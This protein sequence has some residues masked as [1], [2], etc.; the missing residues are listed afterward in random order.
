MPRDDRVA[1]C[2]HLQDSFGTDPTV[3]DAMQLT[4]LEHQQPNDVVGKEVHQQF[5]LQHGRALRAQQFH[6]HGGLDVPKAQFNAP[7]MGV[8][9]DLLLGEIGLVIEPGRDHV[10]GAA[11]TL[12]IGAVSANDPHRE[13]VGQL[14]PLLGRQAALS[15]LLTGLDPSLPAL[16]G[17]DLGAAAEVQLPGV[18]VAADEVNVFVLQAANH[19][20]G[21][22]EA[23]GDEEIA[24]LQSV[25]E[26]IIAAHFAGTDGALGKVAQA[27][28]VKVD[29]ADQ[30][31]DGKAAAFGLTRGQ[32]KD[33][34][35]GGAV[36]DLHRSAVY[37]FDRH[38][39][40]VIVA[41]H[42]GIAG[43]HEASPRAGPGGR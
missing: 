12:A 3:I 17:V 27:A 4:G 36:E 19:F 21:G 31:D 40:P 2:Q 1:F 14:L 35:V 13:G 15:W 25:F 9:A 39:A 5:L 7:T 37:G 16:V 43:R 11:T 24:R 20:V 32:G 26:L 29:Q 10:A 34:A 41:A 18:V 30:G 28:V 33:F 42:R 6:A 22:L 8:E 38:A 23:V